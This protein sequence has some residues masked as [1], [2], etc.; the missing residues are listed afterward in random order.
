MKLP[1]F[2]VEHFP[3][4]L[5]EAAH[6]RVKLTPV[7]FEWNESWFTEAEANCLLVQE[8]WSMED[9]NA[10]AG[11]VKRILSEYGKRGWSRNYMGYHQAQ[12][13]GVTIYRRI[14]A[15]ADQAKLESA[16]KAAA[17]AQSDRLWG[18]SMNGQV[19]ARGGILSTFN[20]KLYRNEKQLMEDARALGYIHVGDENH[21]KAI[22][23]VRR[24][25]QA[26]DK[27]RI[28]RQRWDSIDRALHQH[29]FSDN[30]LR[31]VK[32]RMH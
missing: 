4:T 3:A 24:E 29:G 14:K 26:L 12:A 8:G 23:K 15:K 20:N 16:R 18:N 5:Y 28:Q 2:S 7:E 17:R 19:N 9:V 22:M 21:E 27:P 31:N 10:C 30:Q 11:L 32:L 13:R 6:S 25:K 1:L